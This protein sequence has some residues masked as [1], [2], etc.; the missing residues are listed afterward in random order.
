MTDKFVV[1]FDGSEAARRALDFAMERAT[2]QGATVLI[3]HV[4]EWSPYSFLTPTELEERHTRRKEELARAEASII[5][6]AKASVEGR[7]VP[8]ETALRYG[9]IAETLCDIAEKQKAAQ[10][11]I[12]RNG[13]STFGSRVFG[14]VAGS[15]VQTAP[16][17]CTIVP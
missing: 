13:H 2:A 9:H 6:P 5:T 7:G 16:V 3:A 12:G 11:F 15:L 4:L 8:I 10:L 1:G 17:P 14:S